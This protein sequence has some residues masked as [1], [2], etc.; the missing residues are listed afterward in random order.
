M[1]IA[2]FE[3]LKYFEEEQ[4]KEMERM[5]EYNN[6]VRFQEFKAEMLKY[7]DFTEEELIEMWEAE[8]LVEQDL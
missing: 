6:L 3:S 8:M 2:E 1:N 4:R 7:E 5:R